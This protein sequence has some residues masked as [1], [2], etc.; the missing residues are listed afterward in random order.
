M[1]LKLAFPKVKKEVK[2]NM[3][4]DVMKMPRDAQVKE[5]NRQFDVMFN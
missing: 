5:R 3:T 4:Y 1:Y 2:E